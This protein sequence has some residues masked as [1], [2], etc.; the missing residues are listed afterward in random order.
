MSTFL[1]LAL[2][3]TCGAAARYYTTL[4]AARQFGV[5][6]PYGTLI[7]NIVGC[8]ILGAFLTLALE[9]PSIGPQTRL[10]ISTAF[11]GSLTTFSTFSYET[12]GLL[13]S[14]SYLAAALN[15]VGSVL[16]GLLGVWLGM[17]AVRAFLM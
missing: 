6:F 10:L 14:G 2:G 7:V 17:T 15:A 1:L 3:A 12:V 8:I 16:L 4:W 13:S 11:C 9:R 5:A